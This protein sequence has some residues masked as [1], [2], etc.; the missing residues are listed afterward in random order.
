MIQFDLFDSSPASEPHPYSI[1]IPVYLSDIKSASDLFETIDY[2][3]L[4]EGIKST[5]NGYNSSS[6]EIKYGK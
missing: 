3:H 1:K 4:I 5:I 2:K 6:K